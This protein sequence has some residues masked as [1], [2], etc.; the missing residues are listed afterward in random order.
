LVVV[1]LRNANAEIEPPDQKTFQDGPLPN[2]EENVRPKAINVVWDRTTA[3]M[4][5]PPSLLVDKTTPIITHCGAGRR[6]QKAKEY[7]EQQCGFTNVINGGGPQETD[8]WKVFG[9]NKI[10]PGVNINNACLIVLNSKLFKYVE[11]F[12]TIYVNSCISF[13]QLIR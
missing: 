10:Y 9:E 8:N 12:M 6:G 5:I 11:L 13:S 4:D 7:L 2:K 3:S 1:D